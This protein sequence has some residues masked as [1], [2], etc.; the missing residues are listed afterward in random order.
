MRAPA[1]ASARSGSHGSGPQLAPGP[2][3]TERISG[4]RSRA[5]PRGAAIVARI[6]PAGPGI[7]TCS[8]ATPRSGRCQPAPVAREPAGPAL[9]PLEVQ[10]HRA[11]RRATERSVTIAPAAERAPVDVR[12]ACRRAAPARPSSGKRQSDVSPAFVTGLI[13]APSR[14]AGRRPRRPRSRSGP[15]PASARG[16]DDGPARD[17]AA[18]RRRP[19]R[20]RASPRSRTARPPRRCRETRRARR[21]ATRRASCTSPRAAPAR[22]GSPP[23]AAT[24]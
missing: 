4:S 15:T 3:M 20:P 17:R 14:H 2:P 22:A 21:R 23:L 9:G 1:A 11:A 7:E 18:L 10:L 16:G 24:A 6:G 19:A 13:T 12:L 8:H 5:A